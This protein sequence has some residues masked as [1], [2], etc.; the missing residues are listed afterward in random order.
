MT[1]T[2]IIAFTYYNLTFDFVSREKCEAAAR[3]FSRA[4]AVVQCIER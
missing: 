4:N 2:L 1:W 3:A